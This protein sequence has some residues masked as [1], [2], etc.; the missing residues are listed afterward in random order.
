M[1]WDRCPD[2]VGKIDWDC[3]ALGE[4]ESQSTKVAADGAAEPALLFLKLDNFHKFF[5]NEW[6]EVLTGL[7]LDIL[8]RFVFIQC[9][10][11]G[12]L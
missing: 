4:K 12:S 3:P 6:V 7:L 1:S 9:L 5:D 2:Q 11:V 10:A 8:E